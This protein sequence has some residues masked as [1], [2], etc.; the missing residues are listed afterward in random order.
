MRSRRRRRSRHWRTRTT[1][2][3]AARSTAPGSRSCVTVSPHW[4]W[5]RCHR[6]A[7]SCWRRSAT[8]RRSTRSLLAQGVI[9]RPVANYGL[10]E[11]L[12][13]SVGLLE[14]ERALP[15]R[16]SRSR[17]GVDGRA[18]R[19]TSRRPFPQLSCASTKLAVVGVGLIGGSCA[20]ALNARGPSA[21]SS[22]SAGPRR[23]STL[24]CAWNH[25]SRAAPRRG[26]DARTA[27]RRRRAGRSARRAISRR[28]LP[29]SRRPSDR[30]RSS[31]MPAAP[32]RMS[33]RAARAAFGDRIGRFRAG[34]SGG[35]CGG[36]RRRRCDRVA[37][38]WPN[39][40]HDARRGNEWTRA[41]ARR[42]ALA[43][44]RR[45]RRRHGTRKRTTG[46]SRRSRTCRILL[47]FAYV[48]ELAARPESAETL[49]A[50]RHG[51]PRLHAHRR[52][53]AGNVARH[54]ALPTALRC[55][56]NSA[57]TG[58]RSNVSRRRWTHPMARRW[59]ASSRDR[60]RH[61]ALGSRIRRRTSRAKSKR[62][63][64]TAR[65]AVPARAACRGH[66]RAAGLEEHLQPHAAA[67][68]AGARHDDAG[69][70]PGRRRYRPDARC[71]EV[72]G[73][74]RPL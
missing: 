13:V 60:G 44:V 67:C 65:L 17:W 52:G 12:R 70:C 46:S 61:G 69:R 2:T 25:R 73:C 26:L 24:P 39:G 55:R 59:R 35:R 6:T 28:C 7:I 38:R 62:D 40:H 36:L 56:M 66:G 19:A 30:T 68:G 49:R 32:S 58:A 51:L 4:A 74:R 8:R 23:I 20:L 63:V 43:G 1:S 53:L 5:R 21:P 16:A 72:A 47:A 3:P 42:R 57:N 18:A 64:R 48:D 33:S 31:P 10:P 37:L 50:C 15:G 54:R 11:W 45:T 41:G 22:A 34:A 29:R 71:A 14:R 9:V 27:R